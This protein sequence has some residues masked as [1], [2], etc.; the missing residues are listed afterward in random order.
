MPRPGVRPPSSSIKRLFSETGKRINA[1]FGERFL[2][3]FNHFA[4]LS[5]LSIAAAAVVVV[6]AIISSDV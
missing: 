4:K 1:E 5:F 3:F 6:P 2:F